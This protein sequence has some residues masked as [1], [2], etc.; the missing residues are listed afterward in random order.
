V[1]KNAQKFTP[2][3]G[4]IS[5]RSFNEGK[6]KVSFEIT[7]SGKGIEPDVLPKIFEL[8]N[9]GRRG[10]WEIL[11]WDW[12]FLKQSS[13][14]MTAKFMRRVKEVELALPLRSSLKRRKR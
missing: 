9:K 11:A 10:L 5:V 13:R 1:L 2:E 12:Q 4:T 3:G 6:E 8:F 14:G 7:D